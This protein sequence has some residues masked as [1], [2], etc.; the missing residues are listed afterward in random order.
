MK[1]SRKVDIMSDAAYTI[2]TKDP[3]TCT[4]NFFVDEKVVQEAGVTDLKPYAC[5]PEMADQ[6]MIDAFLDVAPEDSL[7]IPGKTSATKSDG[8]SVAGVFAKL[9]NFITP[10]VIAKTAATYQFDLNGD[11]AGTWFLDL[12]TAPGKAGQGKPDFVPDATL[13]MDSSNFFKMFK[14]EL[15]PANAFMSGKLKIRGD[16]AKALKME[17]LLGSLKGKL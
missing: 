3:K 2:L 7:K 14:G 12:K 8:G 10:E 11:Q 6:L 13:T 1:V 16:M 15:K 9:E 17:K 4:G 5:H